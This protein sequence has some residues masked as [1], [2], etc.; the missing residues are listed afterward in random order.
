MFTNHLCKEKKIQNIL[1]IAKTKKGAFD[2]KGDFYTM[3][4]T[5]FPIES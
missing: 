2:L 5:L 3:Q 1:I 4:K